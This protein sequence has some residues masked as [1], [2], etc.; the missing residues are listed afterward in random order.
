MNEKE[1]QNAVMKNRAEAE[2]LRAEAR[3]K[4]FHADALRAENRGSGS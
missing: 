4:Q 1:I 2:R 3:A